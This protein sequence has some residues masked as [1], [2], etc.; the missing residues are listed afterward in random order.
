MSYF[1]SNAFTH[2]A[3]TPCIWPR[4]TT[5]IHMS[6]HNS[7]P[8]IVQSLILKHIYWDKWC[9]HWINPCH[10]SAIWSN[11]LSFH[12]NIGHVWCFL[13]LKFKSNLLFIIVFFHYYTKL[14]VG[15]WRTKI[16]RVHYRAD[17][18]ARRWAV[19]QMVRKARNKV[20]WLPRQEEP[21]YSD[22]GKS[23]FIIELKLF[24]YNQLG[25]EPCPLL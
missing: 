9:S 12:C 4:L 15:G 8:A 1:P 21:A 24:C 23:I 22:Y 5:R 10:K 16:L 2:I 25:L 11:M 14:N 19:P 6:Y 18:L 20:A 17:Y 7:C 3:S 13:I